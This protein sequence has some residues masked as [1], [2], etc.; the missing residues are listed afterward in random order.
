[1]RVLIING[2][3]INLIGKR[4]KKIYGFYTYDFIM[5]KCKEFAKEKGIQ[6]DTFQ[7]NGEGE[8]IDRIQEDD[9]DYIIGNFG[10]FTHYSYAIRDAL[11]AVEKPFVEVHL[12]NV[13]SREEWR[14]K[15]VI[16]DIAIGVITGF[17]Y[18]SYI[19]ALQY[20]YEVK[21]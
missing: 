9:F 18:Y 3:N 1:M 14:R 6:L 19:L 21:K 4:E 17:G 2:P 16:S 11:L 20:I 15:S 8:I 5:D 7:S 12:S 13:F 10:A